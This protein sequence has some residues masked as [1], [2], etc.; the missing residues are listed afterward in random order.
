M[1]SKTVIKLL[2]Y[3]VFFLAGAAVGLI[4][5]LAASHIPRECVQEHFEESADIMCENP[6]FYDIREGLTASKTDRYADS[7]LLNIAYNLD[8]GTPLQTVMLCPLYYDATK[9]A[10]YRLK[11]VVYD[12]ALSN[13]QYL[14]Y[15][16]GLAAVIRFLHI[17]MNAGE[18]YI[19]LGILMIILNLIPV[20]LLFRD[21]LKAEAAGYLLSLVIVRI[22]YVP[23]SFEY[24]S[25]FIVMPLVAIP[26]LLAA[27]RGQYDLCPL[28][29]MLGGLF[30]NYFDFL[31]TETVTFTIPV[32]IVFR[33]RYVQ[34]GTVR[35]ETVWNTVFSALAWG[36]GYI[37]MWLAKWGLASLILKENAM[38]YVMDHIEERLDGD[39]GI[40]YSE[41]FLGALKRNISQLYPSGY[42]AVGIAVLILVLLAAAVW[43]FI[44]RT[45][46][47]W[48]FLTVC[49]L[50]GIIPYV[51]YLILHNHSYIHYFFTYR[52]QAGTVFALFL[53]ASSCC[54]VHRRRKK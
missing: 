27:K 23:S 40:S 32:L 42:G 2:N 5:L 17:F 52:A 33:Y 25:M 35:S 41:Y 14:R 19:F 53:M 34:E 44:F 50:I 54:A 39:I 12:G 49:F 11:D 6:V 24:L 26:A 43:V 29:F 46:P 51:R 4:L 31:T 48:K 18:I 3:P 36:A 28:I 30:A 7:L 20:F 10:N 15:W 47:D 37:G 1:T 13:D 21:G 9:N 38:T 8:T 16:H 45:G 22:W